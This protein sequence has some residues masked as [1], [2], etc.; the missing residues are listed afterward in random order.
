M[1]DL[2]NL[3][4]ST[5]GFDRLF[6]LMDSLSGLETTPSYP[7]YNI[8][9]NAKDENAYAISMAVAG[10]SED[11]INIELKEQV[12]TVRAEKQVRQDND[13]EVLYQGI[14]GR[15]FERHFHLADHVQV[16]G[17]RLE[18]GLLHI[19]LKREIPE[20]KKPRTI[21]ISTA[22]SQSGKQRTIE[23]SKAA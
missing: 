10:F 5:I 6:S 17:A 12:L 4:R 7:P 20:E 23:S 11:E 16:T 15:S 2:N 21:S 9:R 1:R 8:T 13:H 22:S 18:N 3:Y 19:E 14:A